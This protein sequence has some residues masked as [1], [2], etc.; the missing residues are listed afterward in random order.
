MVFISYSSKDKAVV[1]KKLVIPLREQGIN[2]FFSVDTISPA[3]KWQEIIGSGLQ[4]CNW[5]LA[6]VSENSIKS[7]W[8]GEEILYALGRNELKGRIMPVLIDDSKPEDL[9]WRL[10]QIQWID[11]QKDDPAKL[12]QIISKIKEN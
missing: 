7:E 5:F 2:V 3:D 9:N 6:V 11:L 8:V 12:D 10:E 1:E 4:Q